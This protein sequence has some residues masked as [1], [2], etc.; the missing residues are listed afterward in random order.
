M[1]V[2]GTAEDQLLI[3]WTNLR[4]VPEAGV[5]EKANRELLRLAQNWF[6]LGSRLLRDCPT[7][8]NLANL[9][10]AVL[11][12]RAETNQMIDTLP[13]VPECWLPGVQSSPWNVDTLGP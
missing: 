13:Y 9:K 11:A 4:A 8:Q 1:N 5:A 3:S 7:Q 12:V 2:S 10:I 6:A